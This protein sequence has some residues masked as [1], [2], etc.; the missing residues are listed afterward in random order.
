[1]KS[2]LLQALSC[3]SLIEYASSSRLILHP[4]HLPPSSTYVPLKL[5]IAH[6]PSTPPT[7]SQA[8]F[9]ERKVIPSVPALNPVGIEKAAP[10]SASPSAA[11]PPTRPRTSSSAPS[12]RLPPNGTA[13]ITTASKAKPFDFHTFFFGCAANS[14]ESVVD[15]AVQCTILLG[16]FRNGKE[17]AVATFTFTP[18]LKDGSLP[19]STL[20]IKAV[21]PIE[22]RNLHSVTLAQTDPLLQVLVADD[23]EL[24]PLEE[25]KPFYIFAQSVDQKPRLLVTLKTRLPYPLM[26]H[27]KKKTSFE[28]HFEFP[29]KNKKKITNTRTLI[30]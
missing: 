1:M 9:D 11:Q 24:T 3:L 30:M 10:P 17:V 21:L 14:G 2:S 28:S 16:G 15:S 4:T 12:S 27:R 22:F 6:L 23:F 19:T 29:K 26:P 13:T 20:M 7:D 18:A 8:Q 5:P 25:R